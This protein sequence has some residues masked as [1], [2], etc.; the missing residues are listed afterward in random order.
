MIH[1]IKLNDH[2][3]ELNGKENVLQVKK[4]YG[5]K[6]SLLTS[7][8]KGKNSRI[9]LKGKKPNV[10]FACRSETDKNL[11]NVVVTSQIVKST[12]NVFLKKNINVLE[13]NEEDIAEKLEFPYMKLERANQLEQMVQALSMEIQHLRTKVQSLEDR[14]KF[15]QFQTSYCPSVSFDSESL[16]M[17]QK[18][19]F[20]Q[21]NEDIETLLTAKAPK[22]D[23]LDILHKDLWFLENVIGSIDNVSL[24]VPETRADYEWLNTFQNDT[25]VALKYNDTRGWM[26]SKP[27]LDKKMKIL[28]RVAINGGQSTAMQ[29]NAWN[30][31]KISVCLSGITSP[32]VLLDA[33]QI[34]L[35]KELSKNSCDN[36]IFDHAIT[37]IS[38]DKSVGIVGSPVAGIGICMKY[39]DI[40][41]Y[42]L[43]PHF[44]GY[45]VDESK[46]ECVRVM[47][48]KAFNVPCLVGQE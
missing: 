38:T 27:V 16:Q 12:Y 23:E 1:L 35:A 41:R 28:K 46:Y 10:S 39:A 21:E 30:T 22:K 36:N 3:K 37:E 26:Y 13:D 25:I 31:C 4:T 33:E 40:V 17:P 7:N 2:P 44:V 34:Q 32:L 20:T 42:H 48:F 29:Y 19:K 5:G 18:R 9:K 14:L 24:A 47:G 6:K 45:P 15:S 8:G 43:L 11:W